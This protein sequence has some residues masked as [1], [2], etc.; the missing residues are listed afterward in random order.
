[1]S[2]SIERKGGSP[3]TPITVTLMTR[4]ARPLRA[5]A[6]LPARLVL[7]ALVGLLSLLVVGLPAESAA[8]GAGPRDQTAFEHRP[9]AEPATSLRID[10]PALDID[11][12]ETHGRIAA[13]GT[14][15]API[16]AAAGR[17]LASD[18]HPGEADYVRP[19]RPPRA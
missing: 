1:M 2:Q 4:T 18:R 16:A 12:T 17:R 6:G 8:F 15:P 7:S 19:E 11:E 9:T 13:P 5:T 14:A 3:H 10:R